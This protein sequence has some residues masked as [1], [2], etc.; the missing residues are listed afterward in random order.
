MTEKEWFE[1]SRLAWNA[2][3]CS[4]AK[5]RG[6]VGALYKVSRDA[7]EEGERLK[8][9]RKESERLWTAAMERD[10]DHKGRSDG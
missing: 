10:N 2:A 9:T 8:A 3:K 4:I 6:F 1:L 5:E 7:R